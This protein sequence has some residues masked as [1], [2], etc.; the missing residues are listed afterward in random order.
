MPQLC[1]VASGAS[2]RAELREPP[3][4]VQNPASGASDFAQRFANM[5]SLV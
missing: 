2:G 1:D 5:R 3:P 4:I